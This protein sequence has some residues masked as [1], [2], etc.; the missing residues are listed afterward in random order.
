MSI[1]NT[2]YLGFELSN[3]L[4]PGASPMCNDLSVVRR[5]EDAG[6]PMLIMYSIFQ[7]QIIREQMALNY[8]MEI[9]DNSNPETVTYLPR[10]DEFRV[11]PDEYL[12]LLGKIK[13]AVHIPVVASLNGRNL[14]GWVDYA[15]EL[16]QAGADAIELNIY[17]PILDPSVD[18]ASVENHSI[19]VIREVR[20]AVKVPLAVKI[21]P[22]YTNVVHFAARI[23]KLGVNGIVLFNRF[24]QPDIDIENLDVLP[25]LKLSTPVELLQ[26]IRYTAALHGKVKADLA[27]TGG[28]HSADGVIKSIMAGASAVQMVSAL[29]TH[30]PDYLRRIR[31]DLVH[32]LEFHEY[33]SLA[34]AKGSMSLE[35]TPNPAA[36]ERGNYMRILQ[37]WSPE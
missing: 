21:S 32:W 31:N 27:V 19:D 33:K 26:R 5:L 4:I 22:F 23:D 29:L 3:P 24:Y 11:G 10:P 2:N 16:Q 14:G 36:F 34:Q 12:E 18:A 8:G 28:V 30:G 37:T 17:D 9:A 35:N 25:D 7:E 20:Q 13:R 15:K 1:L 6:A